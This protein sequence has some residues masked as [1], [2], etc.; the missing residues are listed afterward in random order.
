MNIFNKIK[1]ITSKEQYY[2]LQNNLCFAYRKSVIEDVLPN[3]AHCYTI[4]A[5][6]KIGR[7]V[8][9]LKKNVFVAGYMCN[10]IKTLE[11]EVYIVLEEC[12]K[13]L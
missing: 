5:E 2:I 13:P 1:E 4:G 9:I 6:P 8:T 7:I 12:V 10:I 3:W 11:D